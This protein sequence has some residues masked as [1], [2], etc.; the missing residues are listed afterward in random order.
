[1]SEVGNHERDA[2]GERRDDQESAR[3]W[4][5]LE[6][7]HDSLENEQVPEE[8]TVG[9]VAEPPRDAG[10]QCVANGAGPAGLKDERQQDEEGTHAV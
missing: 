3:E 5:D 7:P 8:D 1:M 2:I 10:L 9:V 4:L 6:R